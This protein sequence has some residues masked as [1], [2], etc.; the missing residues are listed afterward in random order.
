L[1]YPH[2]FS[3]SFFSLKIRNTMTDKPLTLTLFCLLDGEATSQAFSVD[4]EQ[5]KTVDQ[6]KK[7]IKTEKAPRFD[8]VAADELTLWRVSIPIVEEGDELPILLDNVDDKVNKKLGPATRLSKV[9]PEDLP[10][11]TIQVIV[12]RPPPQGN[13]KR[14]LFT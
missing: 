6:L 1:Y 3:L 8:D 10:E 12:Q 14:V 9:F 7:V 11:E 4:I 5:T 2:F 13:V